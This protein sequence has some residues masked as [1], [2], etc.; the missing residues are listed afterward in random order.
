MQRRCERCA[1]VPG[2]W[3]P[4]QAKRGVGSESLGV[5][6]VFIAG[7]AAVDRLPQEIRQP[8]LRVQPLPGVA[9]VLR[10][11]M[12]QPQAFIQL[13]DQNEAGV[14]GDA[15]SL[16]RDFQ[17]PV[18]RELKGLVFLFTDRV[19]PSVAGFL[20]SEPAKIKARRVIRWIRYHSQIENPG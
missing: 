3:R 15:R 9:Q 18:E 7:Q 8:E 14:G 2:L 13:T 5:F 17:E 4:D 1:S 16:E 12:L 10:D 20:A 19:S 11:E 6:E